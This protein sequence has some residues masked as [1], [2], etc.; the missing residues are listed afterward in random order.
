MP[1]EDDAIG[2]LTGQDVEKFVFLLKKGESYRQWL[3]QD[4]ELAAT[5]YGFS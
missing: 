1:L 4:M 2:E 5:G 3:L